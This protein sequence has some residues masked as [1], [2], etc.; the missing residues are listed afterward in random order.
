MTWVQLIDQN[1][2]KT[3]KI[4]TFQII[5]VLSLKKWKK[6]IIDLIKLQLKSIKILNYMIKLLVKA[7]YNKICHKCQEAY[8]IVNMGLELSH[9]EM[10]KL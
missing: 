3:T 6:T 1:I 4:N 5:T 7:E 8:I 9:Q 2:K 10:D